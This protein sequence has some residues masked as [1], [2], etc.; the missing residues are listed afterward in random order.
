MGQKSKRISEEEM[1]KRQP[2]GFGLGRPPALC[3]PSHLVYLGKRAA[4]SYDFGLGKRDSD[5]F[6]REPL[7]M[8]RQVE[9]SWLRKR[10]AFGLGKRAPYGFGLGK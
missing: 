4:P 9:P 8:K 10:F 2:Y 7:K 1:G 5:N 6:D 3:K